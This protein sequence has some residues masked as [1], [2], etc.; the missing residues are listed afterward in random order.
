MAEFITTTLMDSYAGG[1]HVTEI[2]IGL[3]NQATF[4][5]DDYVLE[6]GR[7]SERPAPP[8]GSTS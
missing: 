8:R 1:P 3:A 6:G 2:Q 4:G 7:E 5:A